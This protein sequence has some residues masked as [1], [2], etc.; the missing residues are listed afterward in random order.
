MTKDAIISLTAARAA[1]TEAAY[2]ADRNVATRDVAYT[3]VD[4]AARAAAMGDSK[5][6]VRRMEREIADAEAYH[7]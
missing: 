5:S 4:L 7:S 2:Q 3:W 1:A 6:E